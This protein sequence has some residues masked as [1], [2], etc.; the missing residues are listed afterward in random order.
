MLVAVSI[1]G[2]VKELEGREHGREICE[3]RHAEAARPDDH[4]LGVAE[5][6][7]R[8]L[9]DGRVK[10]VRIGES[11]SPKRDCASGGRG[12][13]IVFADEHLRKHARAGARCVGGGRDERL[14][15]GRGPEADGPRAAAEVCSGNR[16]PGCLS[17]VD[18]VEISLSFGRDLLGRPRRFTADIVAVMVVVGLGGGSAPLPDVPAQARLRVGADSRVAQV[19]AG[20]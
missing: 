6:T 19:A 11:S 12:A 16:Q 2:G 20:R 1:R 10:R 15:R 5:A 7:K 3:D 4:E 13:A 17:A 14:F 8:Q 18:V 9:V